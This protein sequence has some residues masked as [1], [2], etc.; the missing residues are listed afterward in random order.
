[1]E[2]K[3]KWISGILSAVMLLSLAAPASAEE[4]RELKDESIYDVLVDR[5]FNK[6]IENDFEVEATDIAAFNGGD[7]AGL[8]SEILHI[9]EMGF[10]VLSIGPV[11][12]TAT[13]DG[14]QV[15][16]FNQFERHF[17]TEEDFTNLLETVHENDMKLLIDLPTQQMSSEHFWVK[18]NPEWFT[19]NDDGTFALDTSNAEAQQALTEFAAGFVQQYE[20]DGLRFQETEK[21]DPEFIADFSEEIKE[22]RDIYLISDAEMEPLE[23]LD[24][25]VLP[26]VEET[27]RESYKNFDQD[28]SGLPEVLKNAEGQLIRPDSLRDSRVT[29]DIVEAKGFPPT[30]MR[31]LMTQIFTMP[32]I[33]VIQY[34]TE[35]AMN[36][37]TLPE[38]HQLLNMGVEQELVEHIKN[39]NSL[40]NSSEALRTGDL[41]MIHEEDGWL[42]YKR[43]NDE[44]AWIVAINNSSSTRNFTLP[45]ELVGSDKQLQG[46]FENDI[47]RQEANGSYKITLDRE[48]AETFHIIEERGFNMAYIGALIVLYIVFM[49]FLWI[50]WKKGRQRKADEAAKAS[51]EK[52]S[53]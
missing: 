4:A 24:A 51:N 2:L 17:G 9:K 31:L 41:E 15:I 26:G 18:D 25:V 34:G 32:G 33:P 11:F 47:V 14:K 50:V 35:I 7:F 16:D 10:T 44:E 49:L 36:G 28:S 46:L 22:I 19:E 48:I 21:I 20:I 38:S 1:M 8:A 12:A 42:V 3:V 43:S 27:L 13:Y 53:N 40:R 37:E 52:R 45:A 6:Q 5:Y 29:S 23:G 39:L 30:R